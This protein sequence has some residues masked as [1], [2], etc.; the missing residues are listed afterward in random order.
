MKCNYQIF[1]YLSV[2]TL[3]AVSSQ[4]RLTLSTSVC[5]TT[6]EGVAD[7]REIVIIRKLKTKRLILH[8]DFQYKG[9]NE[10]ADVSYE[11]KH[12]LNNTTILVLKCYIYTMC[13]I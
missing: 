9:T 3:K 6:P 4:C 12:D 7:A 13:D 10:V 1:V 2:A 5:F 11:I 8:T